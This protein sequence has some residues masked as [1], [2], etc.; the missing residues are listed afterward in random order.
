MKLNKFTATAIGV[1]VVLSGT[2]VGVATPASAAS[3]CTTWISRDQ[4]TGY[5]KCTG[6]NTRLSNHR[7]KVVCMGPRGDT[8]NVYGKWVN[9]RHGETSKAVCTINPVKSGVGVYRIS[10]ETDEPL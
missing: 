8:A 7:V 4:S 2:V 9:T 1:G 10:I 3:T 5:G 6:G